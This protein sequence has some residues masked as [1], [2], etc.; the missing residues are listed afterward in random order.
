[1][2]D[3]A[4]RARLAHV[5]EVIAEGWRTQV[6]AVATLSSHPGE[7][8]VAEVA[9]VTR[10]ISG[11]WLL[12]IALIGTLPEDAARAF[13]ADE[14]EAFL[15]WGLHIQRADALADL[16]KD[17]E[18]GL[19]SSFAGR[20]AWER[21]P[22][23]YLPACD[24]RDAPALYA[25]VAGH[26]VDE[27]CVRGGVAPAVLGLRL[28]GLGGVHGLLAWIHGFLLYRYLAHPLCRREVRDPAFRAIWEQRAAW[29]PYVEAGRGSKGGPAEA[30]SPG[31]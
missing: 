3:L 29:G 6:D 11:L 27:A 4:G 1:M 18:D 30:P 12:M 24:R 21:E 22:S 26:R 31:A 9:G 7:V 17:M 14:E 16:E 2:Q 25:M 19:I 8:S 28:S 20:L 15:D 23:R 13:T 5:V 10:R